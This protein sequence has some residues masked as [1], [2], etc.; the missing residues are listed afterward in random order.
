MCGTSVWYL[1][2]EERV[3]APGTVS[4]RRSVAFGGVPGGSV[5]GGGWSE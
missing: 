1:C 5:V 2:A 4:T 3:A